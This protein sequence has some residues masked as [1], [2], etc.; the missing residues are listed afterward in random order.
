MAGEYLP[1]QSGLKRVFTL[2]WAQYPI[3]GSSIDLRKLE[4]WIQRKYPEKKLYLAFYTMPKKLNSGLFIA[5]DYIGGGKYDLTI[6]YDIEK[7]GVGKANKKRGQIQ[8]H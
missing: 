5:K 7:F 1:N 4:S 8:L 2:K 6:Y 3:N